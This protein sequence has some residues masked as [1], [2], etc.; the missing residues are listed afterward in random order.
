M[1]AGC[2]ISPTPGP[3]QVA[4]RIVRVARSRTSWVVPLVSFSS[5]A[6]GDMPPRN[7]DAFLRVT[8]RVREVVWDSGCA[9][10]APG[11]TVGEVVGPGVGGCARWSSRSCVVLV[12]AHPNA[13]DAGRCRSAFEDELV[14]TCPEL[15]DDDHDDPSLA[16]DSPTVPIAPRCHRSGPKGCRSDRNCGRDVSVT[17]W[18]ACRSSRRHLCDPAARSEPP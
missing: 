14:S 11:T 17:C 9:D 18:P 8:E 4:P 6:S 7:A 3:T 2:S 13:G 16:L 1:L 5:S 15:L 10:R 12:P